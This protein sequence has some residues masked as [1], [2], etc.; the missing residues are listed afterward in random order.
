[1]SSTTRAPQQSKMSSAEMLS[2]FSS[3]PNSVFESTPKR[4]RKRE[5]TPVGRQT[6]RS[7]VNKS[8]SLLDNIDD[9]LELSK[10]Q[11][12]QEKLW[13]MLDEDDTKNDAYINDEGDMEVE[14]KHV[15]RR[16]KETIDQPTVLEEYVERPGEEHGK[17]FRKQKIK[18]DYVDK[19][20]ADAI[21]EYI[22]NK[23]EGIPGIKFESARTEFKKFNY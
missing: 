12:T 10:R 1:M 3:V 11:Q 2:I 13:K 17:K 19:D 6:K 20:S 16:R 5:S 15:R 4:S 18:G 22:P 21:I 23:F 14:S 9:L 8:E 7:R